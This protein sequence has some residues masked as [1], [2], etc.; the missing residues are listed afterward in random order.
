MTLPLLVVFLSK[1][2]IFVVLGLLF[3]RKAKHNVMWVMTAL[4]FVI[5]TALLITYY[6]KPQALPAF[7]AAPSY[8]FVQ[9]AAALLCVTAIA[10]YMFTLGTHRVALP[11]WHQP[12][13]KPSG[14]V[15]WG[16]YRRV[17]HPFYSSYV[18]FFAASLLLAPTWP[19]LVNALYLYA[20]INLTAAREERD[21]AAHFGAEY[22]R[23]LSRTGRFFPN[24]RAKEA[25]PAS[26]A[27]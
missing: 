2:A 12:D 17:R 10:L 24:L 3:F 6:F 27:S 18:I 15:T 1:F 5:N 16:P 25:E 8:Q 21:L 22:Q 26:L 7:T 23:Y 9:A 11:G 19:I 4:P 13:D 20:A 14:L